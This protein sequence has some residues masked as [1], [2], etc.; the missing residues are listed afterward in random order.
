LALYTLSLHDALPIWRLSRGAVRVLSRL[1]A[2]N[3]AVCTLSIPE[4]RIVTR[5]DA[6]PLR[7]LTYSSGR[8][9]HLKA[10]RLHNSDPSAAQRRQDRKS[11]R[12]NS[13]HVKI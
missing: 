4:R 9:E 7:K 11:T 2:A 5:Q 13:S 12:L 10:E 6:A 3:R 8:V 1:A